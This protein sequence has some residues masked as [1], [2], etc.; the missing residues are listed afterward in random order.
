MCN[1]LYLLASDTEEYESQAKKYFNLWLVGCTE[2]E[3]QERAEAQ[4]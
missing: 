1:I 3:N 2:N 4:G